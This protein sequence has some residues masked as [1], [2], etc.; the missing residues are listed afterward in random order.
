MFSTQ[1]VTDAPVAEGEGG[2]EDGAMEARSKRQ[3]TSGAVSE[4][5]LD[6]TA[7]L[8]AVAAVDGGTRLLACSVRPAAV[9]IASQPTTP[10]PSCRDL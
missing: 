7:T 10:V 3:C 2:G 8:L 9:R 6:A 4:P 5:P 1:V